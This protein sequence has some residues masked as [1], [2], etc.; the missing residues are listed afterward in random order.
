MICMLHFLLSR[1][2]GRVLRR[3]DLK[4]VAQLL[5][6]ARVAFR[7]ADDP[8]GTYNVDATLTKIKVHL[9]V[10]A[11]ERAREVGDR[12]LMWIVLD[13]NESCRG[14]FA[15]EKKMPRV[16]QIALSYQQRAYSFLQCC[17]QVRVHAPKSRFLIFK[18]GS[19]HFI[20]G[21]SNPTPCRLESTTACTNSFSRHSTTLPSCATLARFSGTTRCVQGA[22]YHGISCVT[23]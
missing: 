2:Q 18:F 23:Y 7:A 6:S 22:S 19:V 16:R 15:F 5:K 20:H 21:P 12:R 11:I 17:Y 8:S 4:T 14:M 1:V 13:L 3:R 10:K 9:V